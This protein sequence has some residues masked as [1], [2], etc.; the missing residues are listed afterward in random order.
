MDTERAPTRIG[1]DPDAFEAF[2]R[3]H[4]AYVSR[5]VALRTTD[6]HTAADLTA[7]IFS[8]S[9][10]AA[11]SYRRSSGPPRAWLTGIA[12]NVVADHARSAAR[13]SAAYGRLQGR[14]LLDE[15]ATE[16][17]VDRISAHARG[18]E[19]LAHVATLPA[20]QRDLVEL[21]AVDQ[22]PLAEAA[23]VLGISAGTAR[24][25]WHR[26]RRA[27]RDAVPALPAPALEASS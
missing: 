20:G 11:S 7:E 2:Y 21:V 24:V 15:D 3:E 19:L 17:I 10:V 14:R 13:E 9:I 6:P 5:Y 16:R 1:A 4:L 25:R 8:R 12:R 27:L 26:A 18:R 22:L 23:Q